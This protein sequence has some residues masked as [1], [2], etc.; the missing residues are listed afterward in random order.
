MRIYSVGALTG[1]GRGELRIW[2]R[3]FRLPNFLGLLADV[4]SRLV[5][6]RDS[7]G[8]DLFADKDVLPSDRIQPD[9][10]VLRQ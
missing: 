2:L 9:G 4:I 8:A 5:V 7:Y 6:S 1:K 10:Q 3:F